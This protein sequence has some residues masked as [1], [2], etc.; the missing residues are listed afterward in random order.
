MFMRFECDIAFHIAYAKYL[1][2]PHLLFVV[3][4]L[5]LEWFLNPLLNI[6][7]KSVLLLKYIGKFRQGYRFLGS[8]PAG[9]SLMPI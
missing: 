3:Y 1:F 6:G 9:F 2:Q 8:K 7:F 5:S 4:H